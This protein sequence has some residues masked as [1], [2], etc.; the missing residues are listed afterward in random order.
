MKPIFIASNP[1]F[2]DDDYNIVKDILNGK[3]SEKEYIESKKQVTEFFEDTFNSL[4]IKFLLI[5]FN[6]SVKII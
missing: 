2:Q 4:R 6:K 1:N 5:I 3:I